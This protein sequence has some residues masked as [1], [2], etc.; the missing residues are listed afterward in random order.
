MLLAE[1]KY[2]MPIQVKGAPFKEKEYCLAMVGTRTPSGIAA[3]TVNALV[4]TLKGMNVRIVSGLAQGIDTLCHNAA[5][6]NNLPTTAVIAQGLD[7]PLHS[8]QRIVADKILEHGGN[9]VSCFED[10][11]P[12][13]QGNFVKRNTIITGMSNATIVVESRFKGGAM[14]TARFCNNEN[15]PLFAVPGSPMSPTSEGCNWLLFKGIARPIW[16][17]EELPEILGFNSLFPPE[18]ST[19]VERGQVRARHALPLQ[20]DVYLE[21]RFSWDTPGTI[22]EIN[23]I[24]EQTGKPINE[25]LAM[26][27]E[28]E[29]DGKCKVDGFRVIF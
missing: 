3:N 25:V 19:L 8:G 17:I 24:C 6:E 23:E 26:L 16:K 20:D 12:A 2:A 28:M 11:I 4:K 21:R 29:L 13:S 27:T 22:L 1:S 15:K 5:M 9:I 10:G 7:M 18:P 14:H